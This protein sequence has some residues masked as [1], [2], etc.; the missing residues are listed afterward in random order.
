[1]VDISYSLNQSVKICTIPIIA[2]SRLLVNI[3]NPV[4]ST[5]FD[6][7]LDFDQLSSFIFIF[8]GDGLQKIFLK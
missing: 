1:M 8:V 6:I 5:C 2:Y 7:F 4:I 3:K